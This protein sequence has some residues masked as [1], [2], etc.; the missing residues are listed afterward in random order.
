MKYY[1]LILLVLIVSC[2]KG[3]EPTFDPPTTEA[4][5]DMLEQATNYL[6][7]GN[8]QKAEDILIQAQNIGPQL[9]MAYYMRGILYYQK[10]EI[11]RSHDFFRD[12]ILRAEQE[13]RISLIME[14]NSLT[15]F[16]NSEEINSLIQNAQENPA[17]NISNLNEVLKTSP[18]NTDALSLLGDANQKS[19]PAKSIEYYERVLKIHPAH[20]RA[21]EQLTQLYES[22]QDDEK[23][24]QNLEARMKYYGVT[25]QLRHKLA[26]KNIEKNK[27]NEAITLLERNTNE[28]EDYFESFIL[29]AEIYTDKKEK[30]K[31]K[32]KLKLFSEIDSDTFDNQRKEDYNNLQAK[33]KSLHTALDTQ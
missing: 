1:I 12:A 5:F 11:N 23:L 30:K 31:A 21:L 22:Q 3:E 16:P 18:N 14:I 6:H 28:F 33:V 9:P 20:T 26:K 8:I 27:L 13:E 19:N 4:Y 17:A 29:L 24:I 25:P 32:R 15:S 7:N 2:S 10:G